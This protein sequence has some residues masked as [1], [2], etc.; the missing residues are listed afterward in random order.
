[1]K[2]LFG[3]TLL[4][5]H[6]ICAYGANATTASLLSDA[7]TS[8]RLT[9]LATV[10]D[11]GG[12]DPRFA[13]FLEEVGAGNKTF[14]VPT[15]LTLSQGLSFIT[16]IPNAVRTLQYQIAHG[17]IFPDTAPV[18]PSHVVAPSVLNDNSTVFLKG[19]DTQL[20]VA[21]K[22]DD[23]QLHI[24]NQGTDLVVTQSQTVMSLGLVINLVDTFLVPPGNLSA[25]L[26]ANNLTQFQTALQ[27]AGLLS[28]LSSQR[29]V[30]IF[31]PSDAAFASASGVLSSL[32]AGQLTTVLQNHVLNSTVYSPSFGTS[33]ISSTGQTLHMS[34][35]SVT[36]GKSTAKLSQTDIGLQNGVLH[37][38]DTVILDQ[39]SGPSAQ[40]GTSGGS[41][42]GAV[43]SMRLPLLAS[44]FGAIVAVFE[45]W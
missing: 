26:A 3:A 7:L 28:S 36:A 24:L 18:S 33:Q 17:Q 1:M 19:G 13:A 16:N 2:F 43:L 39:N 8:L 12:S 31:A 15:K 22:E 41:A 5:L 11:V 14:F 30:T 23:G 34:N 38:V 29:G 27:N 9:A 20:I 42:N 40:S 44:V 10:I 25:A 6:F 21:T 45:C 35:T 4:S 37:I 32:S